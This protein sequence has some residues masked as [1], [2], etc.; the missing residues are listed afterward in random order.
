ME[1]T[2][3]LR[4][5]DDVECAPERTCA[6]CR[7][8][9][10]RGEMLRFVHVPEHEP[11]LV[12]DLGA[13]LGG[14]GVWVHPRGTCL[15]RAVRGGFARSLRTRVEVDFAALRAMA[16]AQLTR[17][18]SGLLLAAQ[19]RR[20]LA[21]GTDA[22]RLALAACAAHLL[23]VAKDAAGRRTELV[24]TANERNVQVI[25]LSTKDE[26][27]HLT[28]KD[29]LGFIAVL[30]VPIAREISDSARWLAG[31]SEDG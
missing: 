10:E 5:D 13:R 8:H 25:E 30:D 14:R 2:E 22:V 1:L 27:G 29:S 7:A 28:G 16:H 18:I 9:A 31:L 3:N 19:R 17:R 24:S 15:M 6:G 21:L 4:D 23:L 12:A 11:P 20:V 26:L